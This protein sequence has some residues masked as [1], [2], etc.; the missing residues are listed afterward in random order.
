MKE[1]LLFF[2]L[3]IPAFAQKSFF[4]KDASTNKPIAYTSIL[5]YIVI[6]NHWEDKLHIFT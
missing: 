2:L 1:L 6:K 5:S 4:V 3:S